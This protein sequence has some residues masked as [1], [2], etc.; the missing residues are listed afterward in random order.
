MKKLTTFIVICLLLF[1]VNYANADPLNLTIVE[2]SWSNTTGGDSS[3]YE[4]RLDVS[5]LYGNGSEDQIRW[6][7]PAV[8]DKSGLGFTGKVS[9]STL[10]LPISLGTAFEIG[11]LRHFNNGVWS[12]TAADSTDLS[13]A[14]TISNGSIDSETFAFTFLIDETPN[15]AADIITFSV[16]SALETITIGTEEYTLWLL[17]FGPNPSSLVSQFISPEDTTNATLL[18]GKIAPVPVPGALLLGMLGLSA[19]GIKL[20]KHA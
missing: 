1:S 5:I 3:F 8:S 17:G 20:R 2:G 6:G 14:M 10:P 19:A 4:D 7:D 13:L 9:L 16:P 15:P 12:G 11:Q 18:W